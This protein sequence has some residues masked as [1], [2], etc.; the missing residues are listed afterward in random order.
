MAIPIE[1]VTPPKIPVTMRATSRKWKLFATAHSR[2]PAMK[3]L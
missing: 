2:V 1:P 3:P